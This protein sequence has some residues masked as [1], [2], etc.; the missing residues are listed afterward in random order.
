MS[1][2]EDF[3]KQINDGYLLKGENI[4]HGSYILDGEALVEAHV[5]ITSDNKE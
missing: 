2:K 4:I 3:I 5:K 1:R